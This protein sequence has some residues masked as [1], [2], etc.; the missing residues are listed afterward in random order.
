MDQPEP[1][2]LQLSIPAVVD[3]FPVGRMVATW[4]A[5]HANLTVDD[6]DDF[7]IAMEEAMIGVLDHGSRRVAIVVGIRSGSIEAVVSTDADL[8]TWPPAS[9]VQGLGRTV[10]EG[11]TDE[12][13][14]E[15]EGRIRFSKRSG[16]G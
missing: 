15:P 7:V 10:L 13:V 5:A 8:E 6:I 12:L 11:V 9:M 4:A 16:A 2:S 1:L 14:L 3:A